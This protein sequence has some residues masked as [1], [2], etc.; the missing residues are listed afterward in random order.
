MKP[1]DKQI[2]PLLFVILCF[3]DENLVSLFSVV[4]CFFVFS[5]LVIFFFL[6]W[7]IFFF[8]FFGSADF[9]PRNFFS[10]FSGRDR[11]FGMALVSQLGHNNWSVVCAACCRMAL[12]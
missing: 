5:Y 8:F 2:F 1:T 11:L 4:G 9:F 6:S 7:L 3:V 12:V 10:I